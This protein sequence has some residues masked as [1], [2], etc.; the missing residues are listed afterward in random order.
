MSKYLEEVCHV[1]KVH[2]L[3]QEAAIMLYKVMIILQSP[4]MFENSSCFTSFVNIWY[5]QI[6]YL[7][8]LHRL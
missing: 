2:L 4:A 7:D 8:F 6:F 5:D 1:V 3:I